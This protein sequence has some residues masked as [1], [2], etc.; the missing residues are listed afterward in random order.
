MRSRRSHQPCQ[1]SLADGGVLLHPPRSSSVSGPGFSSS[2]PGG[3][4]FRCHEPAHRGEPAAAPRPR[5]QGARRYPWRRQRRRR[6]GPRCTDPVRRVRRQAPS[7]TRD[8]ALE[9]LVRDSKLLC[10]LPLLA[11]QPM[12]SVRSEGRNE[13]QEETPDRE[14]LIR[15]DEEEDDRGVERHRAEKD[16]LE[17]AGANER[18]LR[19]VGSRPRRHRAARQLLRS[20]NGSQRDSRKES[21][22]R[23][24]I[25]QDQRSRDARES[26]TE[27][28]AA[29]PDQPADV[30]RLECD[31]ETECPD[32]HRGQVGRTPPRRRRPGARTP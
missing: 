29:R 8:C 18:S 23:R 30:R 10:R 20:T 14:L 31:D 32:G 7:R 22:E 5:A 24:I 26:G 28:P 9:T 11:V 6:S 25:S 1:D 17:A 27:R 16:R 4:P 19:S 2:R 12:K 13:E 15:V 3:Q 21:S